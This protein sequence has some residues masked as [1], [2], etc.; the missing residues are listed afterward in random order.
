M[1]NNWDPA[2]KKPPYRKPDDVLA[3]DLA[4]KEQARLRDLEESARVSHET[5]A[6]IKRL[7]GF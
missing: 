6:R 2:H 1:S 4:A 5:E 7:H 3:A